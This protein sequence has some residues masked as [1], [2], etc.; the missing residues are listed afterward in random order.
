MKVRGSAAQWEL[1]LL[2]LYYLLKDHMGSHFSVYV[3]T[4]CSKEREIWGACAVDW[5][6]AMLCTWVQRAGFSDFFHSPEDH[7]SSSPHTEFRFTRRCNILLIRTLNIC[8]QNR[9][10][11]VKQ[12]TVSFAGGGEHLCIMHNFFRGLKYVWEQA[13][14]INLSH[15]CRQMNANDF[16]RTTLPGEQI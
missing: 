10:K 2:R 9:G 4:H 7:F 5:R 8:M 3:R 16:S 11:K 13:F 12:W 6:I 1:S 15:S 14:G